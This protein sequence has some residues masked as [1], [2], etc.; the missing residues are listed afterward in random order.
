MIYFSFRQGMCTLQRW[1]S[2]KICS[3]TW[4][5]VNESQHRVQPICTVQACPLSTVALQICH[6]GIP[7]LCSPHEDNPEQK[8]MAYPFIWGTSFSHHFS[9]FVNSFKLLLY[10]GLLGEVTKHW[11]EFSSLF[12]SFLAISEP[13]FCSGLCTG[14]ENSIFL[15]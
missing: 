12:D 9:L 1:Q 11:G 7:G 4:F 15:I 2:Q 6:G 13:L 14:K 10:S 8:A 3:C 5:H